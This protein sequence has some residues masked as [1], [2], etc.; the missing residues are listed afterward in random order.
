MTTAGPRID[1]D[2]V[3]TPGITIRAGNLGDVDVL[4]PLWVA[5][6]HRHAEAMPELAP[7]VS[8]AETWEARSALYRRLLARPDTTLLLAEHQGDL[9]GYGLAYVLDVDED[10]VRDAWATGRP[11]GEIESL[12]VR[13]AYRGHGI[14]TLLLER[15]EQALAEQGVHGPRHRAAARQRRRLAP[16]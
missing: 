1:T 5:V 11:I 6:H 16:L 10:W 13:P 3:D 15:L 9:V 2:G 8:D 14:G 4:E 12:S 7:Y